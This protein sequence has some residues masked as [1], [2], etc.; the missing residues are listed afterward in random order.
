MNILGG[1]VEVEEV[2]EPKKGI[3]GAIERFKKYIKSEEG[4]RD[5]SWML[6]SAI[7]TGNALSI[8]SAIRTKMIASQAP[9]TPPVEPTPPTDTPPSVEPSPVPVNAPTDTVYSG[10]RLGDNVGNYNVSVGHTQATKAFGGWDP[11]HLNQNLVN[12]DSVFSEFAIVDDSGK[13]IQRISTPGLSLDEVCAQYGVNYSNVVLDVTKGG[14]AQ[15]WIS[16]EEL[17]NGV[18]M[19]GPTV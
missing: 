3:K 6:M 11:L 7:I 13:L 16:V 5:I 10:I 18:T 4:L 2:E 1:E 19:G 8:G 12:S 14:T 9:D 15:A 17:V